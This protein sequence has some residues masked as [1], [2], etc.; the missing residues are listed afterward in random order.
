[1]RSLTGRISAAA[2]L[3]AVWV[4]LSLPLTMEKTL[5]GLLIVVIL[6]STP[7]TKKRLFAEIRITPKRAIYAI[8]FFIVFLWE[9]LKSNLDVAFRVVH[10]VIPIKPGIVQVKTRLTSK[11]ARLFLANAITLTPGTIT[12]DIREDLLFIHWIYIE[13]DD[14]VTATEKIVSKFERYLEVIFG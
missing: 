2:M 1:M 8:G 14:M 12:V 7:I 6:I 11:L 9:V 4:L 5:A 13:A 3:F 10:P